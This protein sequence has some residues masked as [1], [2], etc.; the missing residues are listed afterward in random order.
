MSELLKYSFDGIYGFIDIIE[1]NVNMET[2][3]RNYDQ[4][5]FIE[6]SAKFNKE[7]LLHHYFTVTC[8]NDYWHDFRK[9][10]DWYEEEEVLD[11]WYGRF[12]QY[13]ISIPKYRP[14]RNYNAY[15]WFSRHIGKFELLFLK[16]SNETA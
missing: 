12:E 1:G 10:T 7:T 3:F 11:D 5:Y 9:S 13:D 4:N 6:H 15:K 14:R 8:L 16:L 2:P